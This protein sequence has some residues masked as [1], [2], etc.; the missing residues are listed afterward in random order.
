MIFAFRN[1]WSYL[2]QNWHSRVPYCCRWLQFCY[3]KIGWCKSQPWTVKFR[4]KMKFLLVWL[5]GHLFIPNIVR[6]VVLAAT[7]HFVCLGQRYEGATSTWQPSWGDRGCLYLLQNWTRGAYTGFAT[8]ST[9][10]LH[11]GICSRFL[12]LS[13]G[14]YLTP[15]TLRALWPEGDGAD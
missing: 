3:I 13:L 7:F 11:A 6:N 2:R 14:H 5:F 4:G 9:A 10:Q 12:N 15:A 8:W 1:G